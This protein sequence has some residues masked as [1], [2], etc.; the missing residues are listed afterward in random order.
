MASKNGQTTF[1]CGLVDPADKAGE[2]E[3]VLA[4]HA[5]WMRETHSLEADG[6]VH[7]VDY[8]V[9]KSEELKNPLDPSEGTTGNILYS[10]NETYVEKDGLDQHMQ[11]GMQFEHFPKIAETFL[12]YGKAFVV[13]G[14]TVIHS[15]EG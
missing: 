11:K 13:M 12:G 14:G 6:R 10:I 8:Y 4:T 3:E 9:I 7:L 15:M 2:V 1:N 5:D